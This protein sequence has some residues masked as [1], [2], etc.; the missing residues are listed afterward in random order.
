VG[1]A[2]VANALH[3]ERHDLMQE[4][5]MT[6]HLTREEITQTLG[7]VD[8]ATI[9]ELLDSGADA[10]ELARA[11]AIVRDGDILPVDHT[12]SRQRVMDLCEVIAPLVRDP[13]DSGEYPATD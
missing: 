5:G 9:A 12:A 1:D 3:D 2:P 4:H 6:P 8:D 13:G 11:V 10:S 7:D